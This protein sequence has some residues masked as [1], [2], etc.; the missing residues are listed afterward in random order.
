MAALRRRGSP[1]AGAVLLEALVAV[2]I[3]GVAL[4]F[5][6]GLLVHEVRLVTRAAGQREAFAALEA[7]VAG[8][9]A[10]A[11]PLRDATWT[12]PAPPWVPLPAGRGVVLWLEVAPAGVPDLW[13]V[14]A[15]VRYAAWNE[16]QS[17][18]LATRVWRPTALF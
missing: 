8:V 12:E 11:L 4:L 5:L 2:A 13:D 7:V 9:R 3:A 14:T 18:Q 10:G 15:T 17:R 1:T 16:V 6:V